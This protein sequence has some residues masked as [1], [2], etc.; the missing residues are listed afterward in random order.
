MME[1]KKLIDKRI[2]KLTLSALFIALGTLLST[3]IVFPVGASKCA[4]VQHL[5]NVLSA[6]LLGPGWAVGNAFIT[7]L[8]RVMFG[9]GS[10]L[11]FPGSMIG[12]LLAGLAF[13]FFKKDIL[14]V[15]GEV[16]GTSVLGGIAAFYVAKFLLKDGNAAFFGYVLPFFVSTAVGAAI[17]YAILKALRLRKII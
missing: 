14:A 7:S 11:A 3:I 9:T 6:I 13:K 17:G 12:A 16:F 10:F 15:V 2:Y 4:P 8:L 1:D 5:I